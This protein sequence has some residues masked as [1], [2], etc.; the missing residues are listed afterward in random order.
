MDKLDI[1]MKHRVTS[2]YVD[3][4]M[5]RFNISLL[6][7]DDFLEAT[8]FRGRPIIDVETLIKSKVKEKLFIKLDFEDTEF[9]KKWRDKR[10]DIAPFHDSKFKSEF[11]VSPANYFTTPKVYNTY[12]RLRQTG[13]PVDLAVNLTETRKDIW[14]TVG[15]DGKFYTTTTDDYSNA[16]TSAGITVDNINSGKILQSYYQHI[17]DDFLCSR[18]KILNIGSYIVGTAVN[19]YNVFKDSCILLDDETMQA[20][21]IFNLARLHDLFDISV[22]NNKDSDFRSKYAQWAKDSKCDSSSVSFWLKRL[23]SLNKIEADRYVVLKED[24]YEYI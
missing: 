20:T 3:S 14:F 19:K 10:G 7:V 24:S 13:T 8:Q 23:V 4:L 9:T 18:D 6:E 12:M 2:T 5:S 15:F 22:G 21:Y 17:P 1:C 11:G 16:L